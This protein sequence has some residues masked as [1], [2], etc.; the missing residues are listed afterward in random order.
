MT[1]L[2]DLLVLHARHED[3]LFVLVGIELD[4]IGNLPIGECLNTFACFR[5]PQLDM[6]VVRSRQEPCASVVEVDVLDSLSC[7]EKCS[8]TV[9]FVIHIPELER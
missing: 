5:V 3:V 2:N 6:P 8:Q 9:A 7:T 1:Y 4:A